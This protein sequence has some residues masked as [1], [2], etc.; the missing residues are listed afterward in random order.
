M[1]VYFGFGIADS[2]FPATCTL[3][4]HPLSVEEVRGM[5]PTLIPCLNP[6]HQATI[7]AMRERFALDI[8]IPEKAPIV[9][10][11]Q[12]DSI[13]VM[14]VRG[15]PRLEGRH[16]YTAEEIEKATWSFSIYEVH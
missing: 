6:S 12:G 8:P 16:E 4:R 2:M 11:G 7:S 5:V 13:V 3:A 1:K 15:L 10:L 9:A 14:G